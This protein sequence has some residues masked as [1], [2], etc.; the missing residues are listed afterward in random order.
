M[1]VDRSMIVV[2]MDSYCTQHC[3]I[4]ISSF[5]DGMLENLRDHKFLYPQVGLNFELFT[6]KT[7]FLSLI[8]YMSYVL[9][10][11]VG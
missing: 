4:C 8:R 6:C 9:Y 5:D 7:S 10:C 3:F 11:A 2:T 1:I